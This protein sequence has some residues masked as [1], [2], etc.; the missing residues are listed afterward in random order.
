MAEKT[1][2]LTKSKYVRGLQCERALYLDVYQPK[3]AYYPPETLA[4]FRKG[5]GFEASFKGTFR[6]AIDVS[7]RLGRRMDSYPQLT[8]EL[9]SQ[10][11]RVTLFEAG[12]LYDGVL[13]LADVVCKSPDGVVDV[14]EVKN[15]IEAKH[16]FQQD[17]AIQHYVVSHCLP[18][19]RHFFLLHNDGSD[20]FVSIDFASQSELRH[21]S[22]AE[23]IARFKS[24]LHGEE[25]T[26]AMD[27]HCDTPYVC[28]YK[29]HCQRS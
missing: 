19:L 7:A 28:P 18:S 5:R 20:G 16:V 2:C 4:R 1:Y 23:H 10:E 27:S 22:I 8:Q 17:I 12:F 24:V 15:G 29:R 13:V 26:I 3:L 9:L 14:Y 11:G 6:D 25:P 21:Q